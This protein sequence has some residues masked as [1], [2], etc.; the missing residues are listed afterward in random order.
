MT[1]KIFDDISPD[2]SKTLEQGAFINEPQINETNNYVA[3]MMGFFIVPSS[4]YYRFYIASSDRVALFVSNM[5]N[6]DDPFLI[7][8]RKEANIGEQFNGDG[9]I[10]PAYLQEGEVYFLA[11]VH[12]Q[13][14]DSEPDNYLRIRLQAFTTSLTSAQ[15]YMAVPEEQTIYLKDK[16]R[17]EVQHVEINGT[18]PGNFHF[19]LSG[20]NPRIDFTTDH[21]NW[22][23]QFQKMLQPRCKYTPE[24][25]DSVS[26]Y[27]CDGESNANKLPGQQGWSRT[28]REAYCG[29]GFIQ[30][31]WRH[32]D[33]NGG[34]TFDVRKYP[35]ACFAYK[36]A[37]LNGKVYS[38]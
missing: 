23:E 24:Y 38:R 13:R 5:T 10:D 32:F 18:L 14:P 34:K 25:P 9:G 12:Q 37:G 21:E 8:Q 11:L 3:R 4:G 6:L 15:T 2:L 17:D 20:V 27:Y 28:D 33:G 29:G 35:W 31:A 16:R 30:D 19:T 26:R 22:P 7:F 36:G 1:W